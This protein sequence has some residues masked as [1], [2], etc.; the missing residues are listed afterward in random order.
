MISIIRKAA[1]GDLDAIN[2]IEM[3]GHARW[4]RRQFADELGLGFSRFIVL[5]TGSEIIGF[6]VAWIVA[7]ELQLNN[8]G[9][10]K[11]CRRLG[12]G[13]LLLDDL[14]SHHGSK[15]IHLEVS[16]LN[17]AAIGFYRARG[18]VKIGRRKNYYDNIDAIMMERALHE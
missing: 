15:T 7:D 13:T 14:I 18:F 9:V 10:K 1:P 16:A 12:M 6:A 5:E 8:I 17:E 11:D 3:E 4:N 2:R